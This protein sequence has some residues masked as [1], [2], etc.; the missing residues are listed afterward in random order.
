[1]PLSHTNCIPHKRSKD[2]AQTSISMSKKELEEIRQ[3]IERL[4]L[5]GLGQ[6]LEVL[7]SEKKKK[8]AK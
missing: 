2:K 6:L 4:G 3:E 1:M 5:R 7:W 8:Q